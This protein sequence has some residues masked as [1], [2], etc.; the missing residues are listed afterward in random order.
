LFASFLRTLGHIVITPFGRVRFR[1]FF[2]TD[3]LCSLAK[4][5]IDVAF[6]G[7]W[8]FTGLFVSGDSTTYDTCSNTT[9]YYT[10]PIIS[11]LPYTWRFLQCMRRLVETKKPFPHLVNAGK[12]L[13][14]ITAICLAWAHDLSHGT[15][16]RLFAYSL[17][18]LQAN[19]QSTEESMGIFR[20]LW[21][22]VTVVSTIYSFA[23]DILVDWGLGRRSENRLLRD[24]L[25]LRSRWPY[26]VAIV[27]DF[28]GRIFWA[29]T[30]IP[31]TIFQG[32]LRFFT[33]PP[34]CWFS[35]HY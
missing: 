11:L 16:I 7:C 2:V 12:Y 10:G 15:L 3:I 8:V 14:S 29:F 33:F 13:V 4:P 9:K 32:P 28:F 1:E 19:V 30:L 17:I 25:L 6:T 27:F 31:N 34:F 22:S 18:R 21:I 26:Y 20:K 24:E 23:W 35:F 5:L